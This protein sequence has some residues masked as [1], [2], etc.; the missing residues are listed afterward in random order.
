MDIITYSD[1]TQYTN[2]QAK[3]RKAALSNSKTLAGNS[4]WM[5]VGTSGGTSAYSIT[6]LSPNDFSSNSLAAA[7][8]PQKLLFGSSYKTQNTKKRLGPKEE[9]FILWS[10]FLLLLCMCIF[11]IPLLRLNWGISSIKPI[12]FWDEP[13]A[14]NAMRDLAMPTS[15]ITKDESL[16]PQLETSEPLSVSPPDNSAFITSVNFKDYMVARGDTISGIAQKFGLKNMGTL[17]SVNNINNAKSLKVGQKLSIPSIDGI[18]YTVIKGDSL[19]EIAAKFKLPLTAILDANDMESQTISLGQRL[20][21][22]GASIS[23]FEL[24]K[25]LGELF[26][27]P[28]AG[29]LTSPFGYRRDPFTGR[30][31]FHTGIDIAS[32]TGTPI[33]LTLDGT[34]SYT[35]YSTIY[36]NYVIVT[37]SGGYQSMYGHMHTI[38]VK[39]G[40][41]LSQGSI[42]GT[43]GNTG[44][45][46]GPH[47]H[48]SVY[49]N[50]KLINP[51]TVLK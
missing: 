11:Y 51:L 40:Q 37:H 49:K 41:I 3:K 6:G 12:T 45:S 5:S 4:V 33:K 24:R 14:A 48:F 1:V 50:G 36:G 38:K 27:Y 35:G 20:F 34:V 9:I 44:R 47:V 16:T 21:I 42:I 17:L 19:G 39:R 7:I 13:S 10:L 15:D 29:R 46:T 26:I 2:T 8:N 43:V 30:K 22:P 18:I 31:S 32:P 23:T 25:A 28:I